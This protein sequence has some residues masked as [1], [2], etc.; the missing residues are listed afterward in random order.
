MQNLSVASDELLKR[1]QVGKIDMT[2]RIAYRSQLAWR[3]CCPE[4]D[5]AGKHEG[6][7]D[8]QTSKDNRYPLGYIHGL[9]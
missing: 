9:V 3:R 1:R 7:D 4:D 6:D 8:Y 2:H 5:Q